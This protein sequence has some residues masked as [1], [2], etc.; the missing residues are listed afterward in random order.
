[1]V[2]RHGPV[3][4]G[5]VFERFPGGRTLAIYTK[6]PK[7]KFTSV[8]LFSRRL[9]TARSSCPRCVTRLRRV[10]PVMFG[11]WTMD[12]TLSSVSRVTIT[13][14]CWSRT[15]DASRGC[16]L[17]L[18]PGFIR[19]LVV[20]EGPTHKGERQESHPGGMGFEPQMSVRKLR[21]HDPPGASVNN[22]NVCPSHDCASMTLFSKFA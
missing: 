16:R 10:S 19:Q 21:C 6:S 2:A 17:T 5:I 20:R 8:P 13:T 11:F 15:R 4:V 18:K 22:M 12:R 14:S 9:P 7:A 1:M 3:H